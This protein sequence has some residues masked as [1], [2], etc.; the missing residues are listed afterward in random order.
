MEKILKRT[1][2]KFITIT[3]LLVASVVGISWFTLQ[4]YN[5][6]QIAVPA[7]SAIVH[8]SAEGNQALSEYLEQEK[9]F[10][11]HFISLASA[12]KQQDSE[13]MTKALALV[14]VI[15]IIVGTIIAFIVSKKLMQP[16]REAY[17]SQERF[18]QDAAH[19]LR[20][21]LAAMTAALQKTSPQKRSD[22]LVR[23]FARQTKRLIH[24]NEDLLF[25]ERQSKQQPTVLRLDE[26]LLDVLEE[27]QPL[28]SKNNITVTVTENENISKKIA[29]SDYVRLVKNII[30]NAIKYSKKNG[31]VTISQTKSKNNIII[32]VSDTGIGIPKK[33][34]DEIGN[35]FF[36]ASNTGTVDGTGLGLAIVHKILN[37]Y[38]GKY[39]IESTVGKGTSVRITLPA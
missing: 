35:R 25:L 20:N 39:E 32:S 15:T 22:P 4:I 17:E 3:L 27:L 30:D 9:D 19:E 6:R 29:S 38:G 23:T 1:R 12:V 36:R 8:S 2:I 37:V 24:I 26:L 10:E 18:I 14:S 21:P 31:R 33:D 11:A 28:A 7:D 13:D 5:N 16:V 34:L